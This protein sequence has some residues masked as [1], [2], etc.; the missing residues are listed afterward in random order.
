MRVNNEG[1][2]ETPDSSDGPPDSPDRHGQ[3]DEHSVK[4]EAGGG[5]KAQNCKPVA[6][7]GNEESAD[8]SSRN[9]YGAGSG[10]QRSKITSSESVEEVG[11]GATGGSDPGA[12]GHRNSGDRREQSAQDESRRE[13]HARVHACQKRRPNVASNRARVASE[14]RQPGKSPSDR[15]ADE[16]QNDE[17]GNRADRFL[18]KKQKISRDGLGAK[19][20]YDCGHAEVGHHEAIEYADQRPKRQRRRKS[21]PDGLAM[22]QEGRR[23][24]CRGVGRLRDAEVYTPQD[25]N[26]AQPTGE[27][28]KH[29]ALPQHVS[30]IRVRE[31]TRL[32]HPHGKQH[33][34]HSDQG[35]IGAQKFA[36]REAAPARGRVGGRFHSSLRRS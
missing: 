3:Q 16:R 8:E 26:E 20:A 12:Y 2:C 31:E 18:P 9:R 32:E 5:A 22:D 13:D 27:H 10:R 23:S 36:A 4:R 7:K 19:A 34:D 24:D 17:R 15:E 1:H 6:E 21:H 25:Q 11:F 33:D 29:R 14:R 30:D 28:D 35:A